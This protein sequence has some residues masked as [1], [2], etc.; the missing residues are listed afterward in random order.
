MAKTDA[1]VLSPVIPVSDLDEGAVSRVVNFKEWGQ[2]LPIGLWVDGKRT[3]SF[4]LNKAGGRDYRQILSVLE[5]NQSAWAEATLKLLPK[6]VASIGGIPI[7]EIARQMSG[8]QLDPDVSRVFRKMYY[9][10]I[11]Q[12]LYC[13]RIL[14]VGGRIE[15]QWTCGANPNHKN[16]DDGKHDDCHDLSLTEVTVFHER[17]AT[18]PVFA[19]PVPKGALT[20]DSTEIS[21]VNL[22][23]LRFEDVL[24]FGKQADRNKESFT[25]LIMQSC[26]TALPDHE[27]YSNMRGVVFGSEVIDQIADIRFL[28]DLED[29]ITAIQ[30]I[31]PD[32]EFAV[33]C[34]YCGHA[35]NVGVP[36]G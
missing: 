3:Q 31:G 22:R 21:T 9:A 1:T 14:N 27:L 32:T 8:D 12:I 13:A 23:P 36:I 34:K 30:K 16:K 29:A 4:E 20:I 6:I 2:N 25:V 15:L 26:V 18:E 7:R 10:D 35:E 19:V 24:K 11:I 17:Y 33:T 28:A 5:S